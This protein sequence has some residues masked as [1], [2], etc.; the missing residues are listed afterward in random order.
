MAEPKT[1]PNDASVEAFLNAVADQHKRTDVFEVLDL[2][3]RA[4]GETPM[5]WGDAIVGFGK[6][7]YRYAN[8]KESDWPLAGFSP[9]KQNLTLYVMTGFDNYDALL[10]RLGKFKTGKACLYIS[11]LADV[12]TTVLEELVRQSA[13]HMRTTNP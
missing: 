8:G 5:M 1:R 7:R 11:R 3:K 12:D 13:E 6:Y 4:T 2:M 10:A 9:R